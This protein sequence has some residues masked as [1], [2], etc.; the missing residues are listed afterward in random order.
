MDKNTPLWKLALCAGPESFNSVPANFSQKAEVKT[1]A[2]S[3]KQALRTGYDQIK[4]AEYLRAHYEPKSIRRCAKYVRLAM[5]HGGADTTGRPDL[6]KQYGPTMER[7]GYKKMDPIPKEYQ[8][9]D[10]MVFDPP[11]NP[12]LDKNAGHIQMWDGEKWGSDFKQMANDFWPGSSYREKKPKHEF[13][14]YF[15]F[16]VFLI[17]ALTGCIANAKTPE[18][19]QKLLEDL[20]G[21]TVLLEKQLDYGNKEK[22]SKYFSSEMVELLYLD[23]Q[24]ME[25]TGEICHINWDILCECQDQTDKL[26]V[27]FEIKS[28]NPIQILAKVTDFGETK[29][30]QFNFIEENGKL[31]ISDLVRSGHSLKEM[32]KRPL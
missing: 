5:E 26:S 20:Y 3:E 23:D 10:V 25:K 17:F 18:N 31:K 29:E 24:C 11:E 15:M 4:A 32:L 2:Q 22:T 30:I 21:S 7:I 28:V 16:C 14:R 12:E 9:G 6:A 8:I 19:A 1:A 27:A 13:F